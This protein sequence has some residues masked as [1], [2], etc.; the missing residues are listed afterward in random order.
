M[1]KLPPRTRSQ[2]EDGDTV[3]SVV[4]PP[5]KVSRKG[6]SRGGRSGRVGNPVLQDA[7]PRLDEPFPPGA[8][9]PP[10]APVDSHHPTPPAKAP[11]PSRQYHQTVNVADD[12]K[13]ADGWDLV[14]AKVVPNRG[15][16]A[17]GPEVCLLGSNFPTDHGPLYVRFGDKFTP[18]VGMLSRSFGKYLIASRFFKGLTCSCAISRKLVFQAWLESLSP[19]FPKPTLLLWAQVFVNSNI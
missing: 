7:A 3:D 6:Y 19:A 2:A 9:G 10:A 1:S 12:E 18:V 5:S 13:A 14:I 11:M 17:G 8:I 16:T 4:L 15:P